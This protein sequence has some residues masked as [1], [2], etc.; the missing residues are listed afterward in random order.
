VL[1]GQTSEV[2]MWSVIDDMVRSDDNEERICLK[3]VMRTE[4]DCIVCLWICRC[5]IAE[6]LIVQRTVMATELMLIRNALGINI[7]IRDK[8]MI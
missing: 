8:R 6:G 5:W 2:G 4:N 7:M 1:S 3:R